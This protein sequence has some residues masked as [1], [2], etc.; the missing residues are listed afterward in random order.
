MGTEV[1]LSLAP[2]LGPSASFYTA[3]ALRNYYIHGDNRGGTVCRSP[4]SSKRSDHK[5][6]SSSLAGSGS[7]RQAVPSAHHTPGPHRPG[8]EV[9]QR[10]AHCRSTDPGLPRRGNAPL[11]RCGTPPGGRV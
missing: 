10:G 11:G 3:V 4:R 2:C 6:I 8:R 1:S 7:A 5:C 9:G